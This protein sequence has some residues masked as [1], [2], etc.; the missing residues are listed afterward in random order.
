MIIM[1]DRHAEK[2]GKRVGNGIMRAGEKYD[3]HAGKRWCRVS[4]LQ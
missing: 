3:N 1:K 2:E 4:A